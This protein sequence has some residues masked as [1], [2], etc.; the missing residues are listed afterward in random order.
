MQSPHF[1]IG[2]CTFEWQQ[3]RDTVSPRR[4]S[5]CSM[6][7][8]FYEC[9]CVSLCAHP[10]RHCS[11]IPLSP[12]QAAAFTNP[13]CRTER[14]WLCILIR[15]GERQTG[16]GAEREK[17][18]ERCCNT[19]R[20]RARDERE[21]AH[22]STFS[23][24]Q[25]AC[26]PAWPSRL[27]LWSSY[28]GIL[29]PRLSL[30]REEGE[31]EEEW[32][33]WRQ[34]AADAWL[35]RGQHDSALSWWRYWLFLKMEMALNEA[36]GLSDVKGCG[37]KHYSEWIGKITCE[38]NVFKSWVVQNIWGVIYLISCSENATRNNAW[39]YGQKEMD[40]DIW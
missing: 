35:S 27:Q 33:R 31:G 38:R 23:P 5:W 6:V 22:L 16:W 19:E 26:H 10:T 7:G 30:P 15:E 4:V 29:L 24:L 12:W 25:S 3:K 17:E 32:G 34:V 11:A 2:R 28:K 37:S 40:V 21:E 39:F 36:Q 20:Q 13:H 18:R 9:V 1:S 14:A 8:F